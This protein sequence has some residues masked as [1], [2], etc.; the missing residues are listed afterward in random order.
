M[1][2]RLHLDFAFL[3]F[4][5]TVAGQ[6]QPCEVDVPL[7]VVLPDAALVRKISP[8]GFMARQG[9]ELLTIR[10]VSVDTAPR[11]VV[12][13][14]ENGKDVNPAARKVEASVLEAMVTTARAEDSFAMLTSGGRRKELRFGTPRDALLSDIHELSSPSAGKSQGNSALDAVL[15]AAGWLQPSQPGDSILLLTMGLEPGGGSGYGKARKT[16]TAAGIRLFGF[17]L[18]RLYLGIYSVGL[19]PSPGGPIGFPT[20]VLLPSARIDPNR[21]TIFDLGDETGGFFVEE[22]TEGDAQKRYQL[23]DDLLRVLNKRAGQLYKAIVE[24]YGIRLAAAPKGFAVDLTD[25][26][27]QQL[28][29][30]RV[31]YPREMP[32][33][34]GGSGVNPSPDRP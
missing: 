9:G 32:R 8:D 7:N 27:R 30:A 26:L 5:A 14:A 12:L 34:S 29:A 10:S 23:T 6:D 4:S 20:G 16:L 22:N 33:C 18:G 25:A 24:Y 1:W 13:V 3:F 17:Q 11:R 15:E 31:N 28:P 19:A 2:Q 21:E